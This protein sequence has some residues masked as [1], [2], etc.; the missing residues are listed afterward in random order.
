MLHL[1]DPRRA[2][3]AH[4]AAGVLA[5][6]RTI[7]R[8]SV[9]VAAQRWTRTSFHLYA[10]ASGLSGHRDDIGLFM[11]GRCA[12]YNIDRGDYFKVVS[13]LRQQGTLRFIVASFS[14]CGRKTGNKRMITITCGRKLATKG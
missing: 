10:L 7:T 6:E 1:L 3:R 11:C 13:S 9:T 12:D 14:P 2:K 8:A 5:S 4:V